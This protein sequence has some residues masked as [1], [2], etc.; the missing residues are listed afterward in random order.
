M[1]L[2]SFTYQYSYSTN[3]FAPCM[4]LESVGT[5]YERGK[6]IFAPC[7]GL[8]SKYSCKVSLKP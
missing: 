3:V 1:G 6:V 2:E 4:G 5:M 7:M 8:E